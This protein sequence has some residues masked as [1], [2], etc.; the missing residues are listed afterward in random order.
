MI[1]EQE[2][3][4]IASRIIEKLIDGGYIKSEAQKERES[5]ELTLRFISQILPYQYAL[6]SSEK[7][8]LHDLGRLY[9]HPAFLDEQSSD[10][11]SPIEG[12]ES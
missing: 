11:A 10:K 4:S 2:I 6:S 9:R 8:I 12:S 7:E 5:R 3:D 1:T